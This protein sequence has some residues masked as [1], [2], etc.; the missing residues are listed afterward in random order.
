MNGG[1]LDC[2]L[3]LDEELG[4]PFRPEDVHPSGRERSADERPVGINEAERSRDRNISDDLTDQIEPPRRV[5]RLW[6]APG[7]AGL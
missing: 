1:R 5:R 7:S 4:E 6:C 2:A 3:C